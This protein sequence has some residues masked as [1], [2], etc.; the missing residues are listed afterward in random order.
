MF[1]PRACFCVFCAILGAA[2]ACLL[3][4]G[5]VP[6]ASAQPPKTVSFINDIAPILKENCYAC[7]DAK[8]RKGKFE[9][10]SYET[11]R[12][13]GSKDDPMT[14]GKSK[15]SLLLDLVTATGRGADAAP[16]DAGDPLPKAK[17][18]I[19]AKWID[20]GAKLDP[21][22]EPK[23]DL[24]RELRKRW[25]PPT[26]P[27]G[28]KYPVPVNALAF[29]PDGK[30][31]VVGGYH[32]LTVRDSATGSKLEKPA[33]QHPGRAGPHD[34][35]SPGRQTR[36][37]RRPARTGRGRSHLRH[38]R[39]HRRRPRQEGPRQGTGPD[40]RLAARPSP[41]RRTARSSPPAAAT[42][43]SASGISP[44]GNSSSR[45]RITPTG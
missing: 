37:R 22:V 9:M 1:P 32:E 26:A 18:D 2:V 45:S 15:E 34:A 13:G 27:E 33:H 6:S 20:E 4:F 31:L 3:M 25:E 39:R 28:I 14:P 11:F 44:R 8:K 30:K 41:C 42:A 38:R 43:P 16:K 10:T 40:R 21:G 29:T 5:S 7:H 24:L 23:A 36:R 12:K 19:I 35:L 17:I